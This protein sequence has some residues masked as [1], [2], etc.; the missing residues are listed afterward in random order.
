VISLPSYVLFHKM[1]STV[2]LLLVWVTVQAGLAAAPA[3]THLESAALGAEVIRHSTLDNEAAATHP[4]KPQNVVAAAPHVVEIRSVAQER[5]RVDS[6]AHASLVTVSASGEVKQSNPQD[7][8][9]YS[10]LPAARY[11]PPAPDVGSPSIAPGPADTSLTQEGDQGHAA[12]G[13][14]GNADEGCGKPGDPPCKPC[15]S[16]IRGGGGPA[17]PPGPPGPRGPIGAPGNTGVQGDRGPTGDPGP[18][19]ERGPNGTNGTIGK[20]GETQSSGIPASA[21][22]IQYV[23]IIVGLHIFISFMAFQV[24]RMNEAKYK[25]QAHMDELESKAAAFD[26]QQGN[27]DDAYG[28]YGD[29]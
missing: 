22:K 13:E 20:R 18:M 28:A 19:G 26:F 10:Q 2:H 15:S 7:G 9:E 14:K 16:L 8:Y 25:Q 23:F 17:G 29:Y 4:L 11:Q 21:A 1:L 12:Q 6:N 5:Q 3:N 27:M 24:L